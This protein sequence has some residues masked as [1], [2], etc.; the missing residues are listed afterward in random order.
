L[1]LKDSHLGRLSGRGRVSMGIRPEHIQV[2]T[3]E[4]G[5]WIAATV[6]VT[7]LMGN[8]TFVFLRLGGAKVIA[9]AA[10]DFRAEIETPVWIR[11]EMDRA[12]FF[13]AATGEALR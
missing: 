5:G 11:L 9:R 12:D 8:E 1:P 2:E 7:E 3:A 6:Y 13:D 10:A 4:R